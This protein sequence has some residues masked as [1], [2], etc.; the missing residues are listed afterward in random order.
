MDREKG[1]FDLLEAVK[2]ARSRTALMLQIAG[3]E[4]QPNI[5]K[6]VRE[7]IRDL[8]IEDIV[9][10]NGPVRG[11]RKL[12]LF[13][14]STVLVL[15]SY[16]E[17]LPLVL[18]EAAA[19]GLA[20]ITTPVGA[21]PEFFQNGISAVFVDPK[22]P[23]GLANALIELVQRKDVRLRLAS[24]ARAMFTQRLARSNIFDSLDRVYRNISGSSG[25]MD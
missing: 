24:A 22:D 16:F 5:E 13:Q 20:I 7:R 2:Q 19:A 3:P 4:R 9:T 11:S 8:E 18:L 10:I 21:T 17:N 12:A 14:S 15:P 6:M 25:K 23:A 1:V